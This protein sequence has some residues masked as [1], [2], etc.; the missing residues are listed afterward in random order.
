MVDQ[1]RRS[2]AWSI[3][4]KGDQVKL[5]G[6][7]SYMKQVSRGMDP[8]VALERAKA[9]S[10]LK[11]PHSFIAGVHKLTVNEVMA[12]VMANKGF[13]QFVAGKGAEPWKTP[14]YVAARTGV[15]VDAITEDA[16]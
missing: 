6:L 11:R 2:G 15:I 5:M 7:D 1:Y 4:P 3:L 13:K 12:R 8:G 14:G 9:I 10:Q 16:E